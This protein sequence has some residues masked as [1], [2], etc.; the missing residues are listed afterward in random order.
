MQR[1]QY[2]TQPLCA[3]ILST[4]ARL[5]TTTSQQL[6]GCMYWDV[7][8]TTNV[9]RWISIFTADAVCYDIVHMT[10]V[11]DLHNYLTHWGRDKMAA[12]SQTTFSNAFSSMKMFEFRLQFQW[13]KFVPKVPI[14]NIPELV[15]IIAW[16]QPGDKPLSEQMLVG[17][18]T[19]IFAI[20][21]QWVKQ[22]D[23]S[24]PYSYMDGVK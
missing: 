21:P 9:V 24:G 20:R 23:C 15:Q 18:L 11:M 6:K 22:F 14:N 16:R 13:L 10:G 7:K 3:T 4:L 1:Y 5:K 19:H 17:S 8:S 2:S 12:I